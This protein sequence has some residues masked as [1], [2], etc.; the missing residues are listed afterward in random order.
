[1]SQSEPPRGPLTTV[2]ARLE[3]MIDEHLGGDY[4]ADKRARLARL[5]AVTEHEQ[6]ELVTAFQADRIT[7]AQYL[8]QFTRLAGDLFA[9]CERILGRDDF[10]RLF[11]VP[12][13]HALDCLDPE[14]FRRAH[15]LSS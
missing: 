7:P 3:R 5:A 8:E 2:P 11:G 10:V 12:P 14:L 6:A 4:A 15:G 9:G 1:M 13:E